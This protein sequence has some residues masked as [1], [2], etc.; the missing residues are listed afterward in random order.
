MNDESKIPDRSA[1]LA[2]GAKEKFREK[3]TKV[4]E[5]IEQGFDNQ[6]VRAQDISDYW[7]MY[8]CELGQGQLY[9]G[10]NRL[11]APII[12]EAIQARSTR[13]VN[14]LFPQTGRH[15][16]CM[17]VDATI[18]RAA[19]TMG[20][21]YIDNMALRE[22]I[23]SLF[24]SG[25]IEGQYNLYLSWQ[26][27]N[28]RTVSRINKK[29]E[30]SPGIEVGKVID[31]LEED[32]PLGGPKVEVLSD[33]D[34]C[35]LP[36][37][38]ASLDD[39]LDS[40]GSVGIIRRWS[41]QQ[42]KALIEDGTL[43]KDEG[44]KL[45]Q[46]IDNFQGSINKD[47]AKQAT[48]S[49]G[50]KQVG[51]GK[52]AQVFEIWTEL[53]LDEG[54]R[55]CQIFMSS[56][57]K[58]LMARRNPL[59]CDRC[60][61]ISVPVKRV[62]GS[63]KGQSLVSPVRALQYFANDVLNEGADSA[64][65]AL[66]PIVFRDPAYITSPLILAPAAVWDVPPNSVS[67]GDLPPLWQTA[68]EVLS[69]IKAEIFQVLSV[70]PSM[71][72][73]SARKKQSQAEVAQEQQI[74]VLT[75]S[76]TARILEEG[77][78]T[79]LMNLVMDLDYQYRDHEITARAF[80]EMGMQANLESVPPFETRTRYMFRWVGIELSRGAQQMQQKIAAWNVIKST[81][82]QMYTGRQ[83]DAV[84]F[85]MD[86][87]EN[88]FGARL[89][90]L[91]FKDIRDQIS[92]DPEKENEM[93]TLGHYVPVHPMDNAQEHMVAHKKSLESEGDVYG[94]KAAHMQEHTLVFM[95]QQQSQ[96]NPQSQNS[97]GAQGAGPPQKPGQAQ[98]GPRQGA[99]PGAQRPAQQPPGM[100]HK[101]Q[102][103]RID[104]SVMPR[105][106]EAA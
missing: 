74:D 31:T 89:G 93:L 13:V 37:T 72:T 48:S 40:G 15:I 88:V 21:Y 106:A 101:D 71:I 63:V 94:M 2:K 57:L 84:P 25:D 46:N 19:L 8:N 75:T 3:L 69:S 103:G 91:V 1:N 45:I 44:E 68:M 20:E 18:P 36:A 6:Q 66:L 80:G 28:R 96:Q 78:L 43:D 86:L 22:V 39:A 102:L 55:L 87:T 35:I 104:P 11:Y 56:K 73:Q 47:S 10:R 95:M 59:W 83:F 100:I 82:P 81:P 79:P 90:R 50:I 42:I 92:V 70:N 51:R 5:A 41:K 29:V 14:Q 65:F 9:A 61:L 33:T 98:P 27:G 76:D 16:E 54:V 99:Q 34:V 62:F 7:K 52:W 67:F 64:N 85:L 53:E 38:A 23:P 77:V 26:Q 4:F 12:Y 105:G 58:I 97:A 17:S 32:M 60:P 49:V 24:T 30:L